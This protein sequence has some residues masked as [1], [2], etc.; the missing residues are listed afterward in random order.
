[1]FLRFQYRL[2]RYISTDAG[3]AGHLNLGKS[4][5]VP[6]PGPKRLSVAEADV[7]LIRISS[8]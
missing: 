1:M 5:P 3:G 7:G 2:L 8:R 6:Y 4:S